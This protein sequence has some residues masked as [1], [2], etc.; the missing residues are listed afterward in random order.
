MTS[1]SRNTAAGRRS[2]LA[3]ICKSIFVFG[4]P[5]HASYII[6]S[7]TKVSFQRRKTT[8]TTAVGRRGGFIAGIPTIFMLLWALKVHLAVYLDYAKRSNNNQ[9][10]LINSFCSFA[11]AKSQKNV[12]TRPRKECIVLPA[13]PAAG[14]SGLNLLVPIKKE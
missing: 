11:F 8:T 3:P 6:L 9:Q 12:R 14:S 7:C 5:W 1:F 2:S 10:T 13:Y 4:S